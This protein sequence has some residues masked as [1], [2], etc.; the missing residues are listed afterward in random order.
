[1]FVK[2]FS[3]VIPVIFS[4]IEIN[5]RDWKAKTRLMMLFWF[6]SIESA[7]EGCQNN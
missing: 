4:R 6:F 7:K 2:V 1:L 3:S 5:D